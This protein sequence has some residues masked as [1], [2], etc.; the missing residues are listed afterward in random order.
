MGCNFPVARSS[1]KESCTHTHTSTEIEVHPFTYPSFPTVR[2]EDTSLDVLMVVVVTRNISKGGWIMSERVVYV[3][4]DES[5]AVRG[6][7]VK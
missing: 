1:I 2:D 6:G 3:F 5:Q 4:L 7:Y